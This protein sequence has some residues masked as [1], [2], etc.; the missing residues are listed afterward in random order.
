MCPWEA[1]EDAD[2]LKPRAT[3]FEAHAKPRAL[4]RYPHQALDADGSGSISRDEMLLAMRRIAEL[5]VEGVVDLPPSAGGC[6]DPGVASEEVFELLDV[7]KSGSLD[8][9]EFVALM[10]RS[11]R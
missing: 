9:E 3:W 1:F 10:S 11:Y 7:D 8:Y 4:R 6:A 2:N 5:G